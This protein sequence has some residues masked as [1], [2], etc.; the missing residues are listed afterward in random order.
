[1]ST[2]GASNDPVNC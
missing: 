2:L 1:M